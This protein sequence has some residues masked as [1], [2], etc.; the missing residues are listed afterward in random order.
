MVLFSLLHS[1]WRES[2]AQVSPLYCI[3]HSFEFMVVHPCSRRQTPLTFAFLS[4]PES[5]DLHCDCLLREALHALHEC[6]RPF[7][8][9]VSS[10]VV[11]LPRGRG[12]SAIRESFNVQIIMMLYIVIHLGRL[13]T[14]YM[15]PFSRSPSRWCIYT[16][17]TTLL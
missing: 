2:V 10:V 6:H 1:Q 16:C 3:L 15:N 12:F 9:S 13:F 11:V 4:L 8:R 17:T 7:V 5:S 14:V